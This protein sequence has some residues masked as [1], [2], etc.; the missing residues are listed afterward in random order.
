MKVKN[1]II[2]VAITGLLGM[3]MLMQGLKTRAVKAADTDVHMVA[4][5]EFADPTNLGKDTS[6]NG[7]DLVAFGDGL[8]VTNGALNFA[9]GS[10]LHSVNDSADADFVDAVTGSYTL[11]FELNYDVSQQ[12]WATFVSTGNDGYCSSDGAKG[13]LSLN[14]YGG[15]FDITSNGAAAGDMKM[16]ATSALNG[17]QFNSVII[18]NDAEAEKVTVYFDGQVTATYESWTAPINTHHMA[19]CIGASWNGYSGSPVNGTAANGSIKDVRLYDS[20]LDTDNIARV[21]AGNKAL[22]P[23]QQQEEDPTPEGDTL[24]SPIVRYEFKDPTNIGKDSMGHFDLTTFGT[25]LT[26]D[27]GVLSFANGSCLHSTNTSGSYDFA[28]YI[29]SYTL[30]FDLKYDCS[31]TAEWATFVATGNSGYATGARGGVNLCNYGGFFDVCVG[32]TP[33]YDLKQIAEI[34]EIANAS[35]EMAI[36]IEDRKWQTD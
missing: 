24:V 35:K 29:R 5:Y 11:S 13:G 19:F 16:I 7:N 9:T 30:S 32:D 8:T 25:G 3:P 27:D 17:Q 22:V 33:A 20:A 1:S 6:G 28:D 23:T 15:N 2:S 34:N 26:V 31:Q 4:H 18:V 10:C 21:A 12:L 14:A 36:A